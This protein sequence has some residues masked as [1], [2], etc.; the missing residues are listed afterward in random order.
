MHIYLFCSPI[1]RTVLILLSETLQ[2]LSRIA[3]QLKGR[4]G[5]FQYLFSHNKQKP[6]EVPALVQNKGYTLLFPLHTKNASEGFML[7]CQKQITGTDKCL[8]KQSKNID[9][10]M[11]IPLQNNIH[12]ELAV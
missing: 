3:L 7:L 6:G 5:P 2:T 11:F 1:A 12:E 4:P 8:S 10:K 9:I